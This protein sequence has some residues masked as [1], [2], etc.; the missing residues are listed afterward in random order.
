MIVR[1][2][3]NLERDGSLKRLLRAGLISGKVLAQK[4]TFKAYESKVSRGV[5]STEA[6]NQVAI[7]RNV[8]VITVWR[9]INIMSQA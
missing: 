2:I 9:A 3:E 6:A 5:K 7:E 1:L 8:S 4:D